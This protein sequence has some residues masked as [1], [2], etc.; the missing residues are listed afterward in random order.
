[1]RIAPAMR[2]LPLNVC[3]VRR[4]RATAP[5]S[6]GARRH[7]RSS[8]LACGKS[9]A[10]S[11][12]KIGRTCASTSSRISAR[13]STRAGGRTGSPAARAAGSPAVRPQPRAE[14]ARRSRVHELERGAARRRQRAPSSG[15]VRGRRRRGDL[16]PRACDS[17]LV[18]DH[19]RRFR[20]RGCGDLHDVGGIRSHSADGLRRPPTSG[21]ASSRASSPG[22]PRRA[23]R[24]RCR[25][26]SP[27]RA[28][29]PPRHPSRARRFGAHVVELALD[30]LAFG[31]FVRGKRLL[32]LHASHEHLEAGHRA[33]Q[34]RI[35]RARHRRTLLLEH[36][37]RLLER[38]GRARPPAGI[39]PCDGCR[40]GCG[41]PAPSGRAEPRADR[42]AAARARARAL[43]DAG[44]PRRTGSPTTSARAR[45]RLP[46]MSS[47]S[48]GGSA[49][50]S[51]VGA[52]WTTPGNG[53]T[54]AAGAVIDDRRGRER[55]GDERET[56]I[57]REHEGALCS[58]DLDR[59]KRFVA[60]QASRSGGRRCVEVQHRRH[61]RGNG[62]SRWFR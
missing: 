58:G 51:I 57:G 8:S 50:S 20:A 29:L 44:R 45:R 47:C 56:V 55:A 13:G 40:T 14:A 61:R 48:S 31:D 12:R 36:R 17:A 54:S 11:S 23:R 49:D 62:Q 21:A 6:S 26:R 9:S 41:S 15:S 18:G 30:R 32:R 39:H 42:T 59:R 4:R 43:R 5:L 10:A 3:N 52:S 7:A 35:R 27:T 33:C 16:R 46:S 34:H 60:R 38:L 28:V 53:R 2:A 19:A 1:M 25:R 22:R 24:A 37:E